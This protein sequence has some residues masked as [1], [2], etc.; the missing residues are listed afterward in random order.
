[1]L[2]RQMVEVAELHASDKRLKDAIETARRGSTR[3]HLPD[4]T[5]ESL[6]TQLVQTFQACTQNLGP[7]YL[8]GAAR[9]Q[10]MLNRTYMERRV[11]GA[12]HLRGTLDDGTDQVVVYLPREARP[13]LVIAPTIRA[14]LLAEVCVRQDELEVQPLALRALALA[15]VIDRRAIART[16]ARK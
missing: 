12:R 13:L 6:C 9:R 11:L 14:R 16:G 3:A 7:D 4:E 8:I 5:A 1:M 2:L 10:L 15:V